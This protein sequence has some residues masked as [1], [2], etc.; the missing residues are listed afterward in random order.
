MNRE[1]KYRVWCTRTNTMHYPEK[2]DYFRIFND[3][4]G[5][6]IRGYGDEAVKLAGFN[7]RSV[8]DERGYLMDYVGQNDVDN[9]PMFEGDIIMHGESIRFIERRDSRYLAIR[10]NKKEA[11]LLSFSEAPK[12]IGNIYQHPS[13]LHTKQ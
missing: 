6:L 10:A 12:V 11:I 2:Y 5:T 7:G 13:L 4:S 1:R 9:V 8:N 3:G